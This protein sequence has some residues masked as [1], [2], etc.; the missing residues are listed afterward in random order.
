MVA[1]RPENATD[2]LAALG[3]EFHTANDDDV[4]PDLL[5]KVLPAGEQQERAVATMDP[6]APGEAFEGVGA[7][8]LNAQDEAHFLRSGSGE[9]QFIDDAGII[10]V[11]VDSGDVMIVRRAEHR[12]R[13]LTPCTWVLHYSGPDGADLASTPTRR[14]DS[15]WD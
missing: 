2:R 4:P 7:W 14:P 8:H 1:L 10:S 11:R 13:A 15:P 12:F 9:V 6:P 5:A 3:V